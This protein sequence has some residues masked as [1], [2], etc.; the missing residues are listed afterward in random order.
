MD[1]LLMLV[2]VTLGA[3]IVAAMEIYR[4]HQTEKRE[5]RIRWEAT[6]QQWLLALQDVS[7][8]IL[9]TLDQYRIEHIQAQTRHPS[10]L[11]CGSEESARTGNY[12]VHLAGKIDTLSSRISADLEKGR[13]FPDLIEELEGKLTAVTRAENRKQ[14][15]AAIK[16]ASTTLNAINSHAGMI[17]Q[18]FGHEPA[19]ESPWWKF[20]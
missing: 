4:S 18:T 11:W 15:Q 5:R 7:V 6:Q 16:D 9:T 8:E 3:I 2:G 20:W 10:G 19:G 12:L 17:L 14:M 1:I 13:P